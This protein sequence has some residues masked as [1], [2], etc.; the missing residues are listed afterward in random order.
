MRGRRRGSSFHLP[1]C[2]GC[3]ART[4]Q[5]RPEHPRLGG[6]PPRG[7]ELRDGPRHRPDGVVARDVAGARP[8]RCRRSCRQAFGTAPVGLRP[9]A[10][11]RHRPRDRG[12]N[13][14]QR[15]HRPWAAGPGGLGRG[16]R[17]QRLPLGAHHVRHPVRRGLRLGAGTEGPQRCRPHCPSGGH[18]RV[19]TGGRMVPGLGRRPLA[20]RRSRGVALRHRVVGPCGGRRGVAEESDHRRGSQ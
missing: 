10:R 6:S 14:D 20:Q 7:R 8:R 13:R 5:H 17:R 16:R 11:R 18:G 2:R 3:R 1:G 15:Q 9:A 19:R 4:R 12:G